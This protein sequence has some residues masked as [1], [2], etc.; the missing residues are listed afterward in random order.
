MAL[1]AFEVLRFKRRARTLLLKILSRLSGGLRGRAKAEE[2]KASWFS[3]HI[4]WRHEQRYA[5]CSPYTHTRVRA[6]ARKGGW[7]IGI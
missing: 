1:E 2:S 7:R 6:R 4:W 3:T 5:G